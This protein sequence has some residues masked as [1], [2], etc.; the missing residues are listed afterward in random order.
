ML[1]LKK[2]IA[3]SKKRHMPPTIDVAEKIILLQ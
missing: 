1:A 3:A 2:M